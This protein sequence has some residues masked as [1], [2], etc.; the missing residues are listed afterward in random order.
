[1]LVG[2]PADPAWEFGNREPTW[3]GEVFELLWING[4]NAPLREDFEGSRLHLAIETL[5]PRCT[6]LAD[7]R[8]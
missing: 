5:W 3:Q 4:K 1:L 7:E 2:E 6:I 8:L